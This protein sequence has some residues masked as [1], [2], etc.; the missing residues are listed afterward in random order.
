MTNLWSTIRYTIRVL[1]RSPGFT[2]VATLSLALG[3]GANTAIFSLIDALLLRELPVRQPEELVQL[4]VVRRQDKIPFSY[5][6]FTELD[7]GQRVFSGLIGWS[8]GSTSNVEINGVLSRALVSAVTANYYSELGTLPFMGRLIAP[9]DARGSAVSPVA[10]LGYEFWQRRFGGASDVVGKHVRIEAQAYT[11]IGVTRPWFSG[12]TTGQPADLSIPMKPSDS[13]ALLWVFLTGRLK[14]GG[15]LDQ[16]RAQLGS[17]WPAVLQAT[18]STDAPGLR[19][20]AFFSMG[21][22]VAPVSTGVARQLRAEFTR[23]LYLLFGIVGLILLVAC[24]NLANLMLARAAARSHETS[25]RVALG[26]TRWMVTRQVLAESLGLSISGALLGLAFAY[27]GSRLLVALM[28]EGSLTP[29]TLDLRP[30]WRVLSLTAA[31]AILTGIMFGFFPAWR[32]SREDPA[33]ALR[34]NSRTL[35]GSVGK[36]AG[37]LTV[38]QIALS[39]VLLLGAGL[40]VRSFSNLLTVDRGF[41]GKVLHVNLSPTPGG[42]RNLDVN[43][44]RRRL[45]HEVSTIPGVLATGFSNIT[46]P[47]EKGWQDAV[48]TMSAASN[49]EAGVMSNS[50]IVS[51]GFL[52]TLGIRLVRGRDFAWTDDVRHPPVAIISSGLAESLFPAGNAIGQV[53]RFGFMPD[54]QNLEVVGIATTARLFDLRDR[55]QPVIYLSYFQHPG[56]AEDGSLFLRTRQPPDVMARSVRDKIQSFGHE[57]PLSMAPIEAEVSRSLARDRAIA[58]IS[59]FFGVLALLLALIGL[60]GLASYT[61]ARCTRDIGIRAALGARPAVVRWSVLRRVLKLALAGILCGIPCALAVT[62]LITSMLFGVSPDDVPTLLFVSLLLLLVALL[63]SY[64]PAR[65]A[66]RIDP[67]LALRAE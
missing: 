20:Q 61:V 22:D 1:A 11:V 8:P 6:M 41:E 2:A 52:R 37:A 18:A 19:R 34:S 45:I 31:I 27:F 67:I 30:D 60:Y 49:P 33:F 65:R 39:L 55:R 57:Y 54:F 29:I 47:G 63:A 16:A 51:P 50:A 48:S 26:A 24:V 17:L 42:Y 44:Y 35:A 58:M 32:A 64:L 9:H 56:W 3:I 12:M 28:A 21:L 4:S 36:W 7:R 14:P 40:L 59:G 10:V 15:T 53:I 66:S 23:P 5:P 25:V 46:R 38:A 13:R 62:R 43:E